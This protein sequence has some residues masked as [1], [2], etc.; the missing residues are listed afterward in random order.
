MGRPRASKLIPDLAQIEARFRAR[1]QQQRF[2][3][4]YGCVF[5]TAQNC[6]DSLNEL[7]TSSGFLRLRVDST[8]AS[9][10]ASLLDRE[11]LPANQANGSLPES[12]SGSGLSV[13]DVKSALSI[14]DNLP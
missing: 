12:L 14:H 13:D 3:R 10:A 11:R 4:K 9:F 2:A 6:A 5:Q 1:R 7:C 8:S